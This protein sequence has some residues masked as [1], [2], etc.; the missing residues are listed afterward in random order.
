M[1]ASA[2]GSGEE[3]VDSFVLLTFCNE[4]FDFIITE[5]RVKLTRD[6]KIISGGTHREKNKIEKKRGSIRQNVEV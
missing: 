1:E 5:E 2:P 4:R 6:I 3:D